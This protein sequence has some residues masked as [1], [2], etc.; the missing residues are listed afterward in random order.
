MSEGS[1]LAGQGGRRESRFSLWPGCWN[2]GAGTGR[3]LPDSPIGFERRRGTPL[4]AG[5]EPFL[6]AWSWLVF[7]F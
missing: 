7:S 5:L 2:E 6:E 4:P 3:A 1:G